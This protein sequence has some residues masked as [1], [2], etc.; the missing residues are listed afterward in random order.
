[1]PSNI[2]TVKDIFH[3]HERR[4]DCTLMVTDKMLNSQKP[5]QMMTFIS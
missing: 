2:V 1:M 4:N 3:K 5:N